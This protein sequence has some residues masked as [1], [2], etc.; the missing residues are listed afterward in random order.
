LSIWHGSAGAG[1]SAI[2]VFKAARAGDAEAKRIIDRAS[3]YL[4]QAAVALCTVIDP[5]VFVLGG[6]IAENEPELRDRISDVVITTLPFPPKVVQAALGGDSPLVGALAL[7]V[8]KAVIV[9][10]RSSHD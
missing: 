6:G 3:N 1:Y 7:A 10:E 4:A 2:D 5:E 9:D 8:E